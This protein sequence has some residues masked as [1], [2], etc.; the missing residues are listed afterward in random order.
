LLR[1]IEKCV[2]RVLRLL[3]PA[4]GLAQRNDVPVLLTDAH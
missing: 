3:P 1:S 4:K 2:T